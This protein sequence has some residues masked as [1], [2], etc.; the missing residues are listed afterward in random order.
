MEIHTPELAEGLKVIESA[1]GTSQYKQTLTAVYQDLPR[2]SVDYGIMEKADRVLVIPSDFGWDDLGS[3]IALEHYAQ[4]DD[5]D[6]VLVGRGVLL[7]TK[8]T[9][10]YAA[11]QTVTTI[12]VQDL[13]IVYDNGS[14]LVCHKDKAQEVKIAV[15]ALKELGYEDVL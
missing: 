9:S 4:K 15:Q 13:V 5:E 11:G 8:N 14:I 10:V 3:W 7:D 6:N 1:I 12:G 2:I